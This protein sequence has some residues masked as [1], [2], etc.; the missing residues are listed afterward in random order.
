MLRYHAEHIAAIRTAVNGMTPRVPRGAE[1]DDLRRAD[2]LWSA[3]I[4]LVMVGERTNV[5]GS[6]KLG[7][8]ITANTSRLRWVAREQ[9]RNGANLIDVTMDEGLID[10]EAMMTKFL[11]TSSLQNLRLLRSPS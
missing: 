10:S 5:T 3:L 6:A 11:T 7:R 9:V 8:L 4:N 1:N 2:A